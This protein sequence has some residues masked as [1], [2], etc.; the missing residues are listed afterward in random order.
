MT[1]S[2]SRLLDLIC[3]ACANV[4]PP[5]AFGA[6][7]ACAAP[8]TCRYDLTGLERASFPAGRARSGDGVFRWSA[9]LPVREP[10]VRRSLGE[11]DTPVVDL[12]RLAAESGFAR[13][14]VKDE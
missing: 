12:P 13:L 3:S 5:E 11:G 6:C 8:L 1:T 4:Q 2:A 10:A 14:S 9:L 7:P